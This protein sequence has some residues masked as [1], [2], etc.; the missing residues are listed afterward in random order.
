MPLGID[1]CLILEGFGSQ[2]GRENRAKIDQKID[3][4]RHRKNDEKKMGFGGRLAHFGG[5]P[6]GMRGAPG[7][8][9]GGGLKTEFASSGPARR[10]R[11]G[12]RIQSLRACRRAGK[13][14]AKIE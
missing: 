4:K 11:G 7:E 14:R 13:N 5:P 9:T 10:L 3:P 6:G 12:R 1:F 8:D 2:V